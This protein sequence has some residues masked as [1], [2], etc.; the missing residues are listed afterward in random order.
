VRRS[1]TNGLF[2]DATCDFVTEAR[3]SPDSQAMNSKTTALALVVLGV[4]AAGCGGSSSAGAA[5]NGSGSFTVTSDWP[6]PGGVAGASYKRSASF[7]SPPTSCATESGSGACTVYPCYGAPPS[8]TVPEAGQI[9]IRGAAMT[10]VVLS[11]ESDGAYTPFI[12]AG[13]LPWNTAGESVVFQWAHLPGSASTPG[14]SLTVST[15]AYVT[16]APGS[17]FATPSTTIQRNQD[18]E[19]AWTTE[20]APSP[21][22]SLLV[23]VISGN[24]QVTCTFAAIAGSGVVP[25]SVL[26]NLGAGNGTYDV[27]SKEYA[28]QDLTGEDGTTWTL[29]FNVQAEAR[30]TYGV[31]SGSVTLE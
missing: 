20:T 22:D 28:F 19:V 11:P 18:L 25:A 26:Q 9:T 31:A 16:L 17:P 13:Q 24:V 4:L 12:V 30:T 2:L 10:S 14:G 8:A 15:P 27:H 29:S 5:T 3:E 1:R 21:T 7:A 6:M 23:N